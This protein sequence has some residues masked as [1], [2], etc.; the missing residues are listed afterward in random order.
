MKQFAVIGLGKFGFHVARALF[1]E[2]HEVI[3]I[4]KN[5]ALIQDV[6]PFCSE[7]ILMDAGDKE[8]LRPLGLKDMD[9]VVVSIGSDISASILITLHLQEIG[10]K[11]ILVKAVDEDH[12]KVLRKIGATEVIHPEKQMAFKVA[13]GLCRPNILDMIPLAEDHHIV[14][15][16][17]PRAFIGRTLRELDLRARY[18]V[19]VIAVKEITPDNNALMPTADFM[20]KD[21]DILIILGKRTDIKKIKCLS[22]D[23]E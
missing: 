2:G 10:V 16:A 19:S 13:Q 7:T 15:V 12:G 9:A 14:Q 1:E 11:K 6:D 18:N 23:E 22:D 20:I 17:P 21:S 4:D 5:P 8:K 3:A